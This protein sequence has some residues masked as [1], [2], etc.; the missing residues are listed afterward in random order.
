MPPQPTSPRW[1][2]TTPASLLF[3]LAFLVA[4]VCVHLW[5]D[6]GHVASSIESTGI[7]A[8]AVVASLTAERREHVALAAATRVQESA[9][10]DTGATD[11]T[12]PQSPGG[13]AAPTEEHGEA[14]APTQAEPV[15]EERKPAKETLTLPVIGETPLRE[16]ELPELPV[17]EVPAP[18]LPA[19]PEVPTDP[20]TLLP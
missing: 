14:A 10:T 7:D 16:P 8:E 2:S 20:G 9:A 1:I 3:L 13:K 12:Q 18:Q 17:P 19:L 5:P 4:T 15:G 11:E 6:E